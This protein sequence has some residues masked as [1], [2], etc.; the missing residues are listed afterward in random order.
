MG[1]PLRTRGVRGRRGA[2]RTAGRWTLVCPWRSRR[3]AASA[4][5][6]GAERGGWQDQRNSLGERRGR[7]DRETNE[8]LREKGERPAQGDWLEGRRRAEKVFN[9]MGCSRVGCPRR[10]DTSRRSCGQ[11]ER[12]RREGEAGRAI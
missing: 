8:H 6:G 11:T 7:G 5:C 4:A 2:A 10:E 9:R 12:R 1:R 3:R